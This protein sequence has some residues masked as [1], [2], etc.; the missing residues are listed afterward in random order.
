[1]FP[2]FLASIAGAGVID[3]FE[4]RPSPPTVTYSGAFNAAPVFHFHK[5]LPGPAFEP[6]DLKLASIP[7]GVA[8]PA[9]ESGPA[10]GMKITIP[11]R[12][13]ATPSTSHSEWTDPVIQGPHIFV[14]S[15]LGQGLFALSRRDGSTVR[16]FPSRQSVESRPTIEGER[17]YFSDTGGTTYAYNLDGTARWVHKGRA[18]IV[19]A[20]SVVGDLVI[21]TNVDDLVVALSAETGVLEWQYRAEPDLTRAAELALFAAPQAV[22]R[23]NEVILGFSTGAIVALDKVTGE[24]Q[25]RRGVGEGRYPDI[26]ADPVVIGDELFTSGYYRPLVAMDLQT[27][28][29]RWRL[30]RGAAHPVATRR[31]DDDVVTLYLPSSDGQLLAVAARTGEVLWTWDSGTT[32]ALTTPV[33]TEAGMVVASSEGAVYIVDPE[34]GFER[35]RWAEPYLLRGVSSVPAVDGRQ[36]VFVSNSGKLY[37][38]LVPKPIRRR[39]PRRH[40]R[41]GLRT[42]E[43]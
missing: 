7:S 18:P 12:A 31:T 10:D 30:D 16:I 15:A 32:G 36:L 26:V 3:A 4:D 27:R 6:V 35:W 28:D 14:G 33:F 17:L 13:A 34:N 29:V 11:P 39:S 21:V 40:D 25:W 37:S 5:Q 1:M 24:V 43:G 20:P 38:M 8:E 41:F 9:E 19:T 22:V 2:F 42:P 23:D